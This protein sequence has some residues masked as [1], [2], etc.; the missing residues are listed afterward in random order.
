[1]EQPKKTPEQHGDIR[2]PKLPV[3]HGNTLG[4]RAEQ[5]LCPAPVPQ[6]QTESGPQG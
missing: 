6:S 3:I 1:M 5:R 4:N 2:D